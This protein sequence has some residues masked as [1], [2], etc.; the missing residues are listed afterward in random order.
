MAL[1]SS[2]LRRPRKQ[3]IEFIESLKTSPSVEIVHIDASFDAQ[4]W[5]LLTQRKDKD[6]S[7]VD[8]SSFVIMRQRNIIEALTTDHH[9]DFRV[10]HTRRLD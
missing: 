6:W 10:W 9:F 5:Q 1:L 2:P 4:A 3:T 7:L 8:C